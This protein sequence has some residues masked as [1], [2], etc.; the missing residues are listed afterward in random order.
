M[1]IAIYL[2]FDTLDVAYDIEVLI[3]RISHEAVAEHL[4]DAGKDRANSGVWKSQSLDNSLPSNDTEIGE[5][6]CHELD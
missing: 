1:G 5:E 6:S 4:N 3:E 2:V